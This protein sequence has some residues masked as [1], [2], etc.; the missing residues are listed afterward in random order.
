MK[1]AVIVNGKKY[2]VSVMKEPKNTSA[3][4]GFDYEGRTYKGLPDQFNGLRFDKTKKTYSATSIVATEG[5]RS[6]TTTVAVMEEEVPEPH[7]TT[8]EEIVEAIETATDEP[9]EVEDCVQEFI[10]EEPSIEELDETPEVE[11]T[12]EE[13]T[14]DLAEMK[15][16]FLSTIEEEAKRLAEES[17]KQVLRINGSGVNGKRVNFAPRWSELF[18]DMPSFGA[19]SFEQ[20]KHVW[21]KQHG[22][23]RLQM[24]HSMDMKCDSLYIQERCAFEFSKWQVHELLV[25]YEVD[26]PDFGILTFMKNLKHIFRELLQPYRSKMLLV[27]TEA[28]PDEDN[29]VV[30]ITDYLGHCDLSIPLVDL[31]DEYGDC[32]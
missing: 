6:V 4:S 11:E 23:E 17:K 19:G 29:P 30:V 5:L 7:V 2:P 3:L 24:A 9:V 21:I 27:T 31:V 12:A 1:F 22:S 13:E 32:C 28:N 18:P 14:T 20:K 25:Y 10:A 8:N 16:Q 15:S 26:S